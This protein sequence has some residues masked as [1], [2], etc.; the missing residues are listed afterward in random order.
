MPHLVEK[1]PTEMP[2]TTPADF[3]GMT[4]VILVQC[5]C[6]GGNQIALTNG[7]TAACHSCST[8]YGVDRLSWDRASQIPKV[9]LSMTPVSLLTHAR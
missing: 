7:Q 1:R 5:K 2:P 9:G 3:L 4:L 6:E 8:V